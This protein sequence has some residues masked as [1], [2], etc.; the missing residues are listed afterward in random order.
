MDLY[1]LFR[2]LLHP[3]PLRTLEAVYVAPIGVWT[4]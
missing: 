3:A 2:A 4:F 1:A